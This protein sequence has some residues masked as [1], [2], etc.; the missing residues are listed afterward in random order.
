M[1]K[2]KETGFAASNSSLGASNGVS[3]LRSPSCKCKLLWKGQ[4]SQCCQA[5]YLLSLKTSAS[6][7]CIRLR[8]FSE[9]GRAQM[10]GQLCHLQGL[11][12]VG[13]GCSLEN[14]NLFGLGAS[15]FLWQHVSFFVCFLSEIGLS[16]WHPCQLTWQAFDH[17]CS[18][19]EIME[20]LPFPGL[21][22]G[23]IWQS[24]FLSFY[25]DSSFPKH[26]TFGMC[27]SHFLPLTSKKNILLAH[28]LNLIL[29]W[30]LSPLDSS[31]WCA[32]KVH[33]TGV[34]GL[35]WV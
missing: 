27:H 17:R 5:L 9:C 14:Q 29:S 30:V 3:V 24:R 16:S 15:C 32:T 19:E 12:A 28:T 35:C 34:R 2:T 21:P 31:N 6:E 26:H 23:W 25:W 7:K 11:R 18:D 13:S 33:T 22:S 4:K 1:L 8:F 10:H 20:S